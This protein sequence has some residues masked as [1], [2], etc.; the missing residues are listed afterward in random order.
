MKI[1]QVNDKFFYEGG[2]EIYIRQISAFLKKLGHKVIVVYGDGPDPSEIKQAGLK[3][4]QIPGLVNEFI[5]H[6]PTM[7]HVHDH[8]LYCPGFSKTWYNS[9]QIC[10]I[11]FSVKCLVNA[12]T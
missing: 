3:A 5:S 1:F 11:P 12:Y 9:N 6:A 2:T 8:R 10:P 4:Y 7:R